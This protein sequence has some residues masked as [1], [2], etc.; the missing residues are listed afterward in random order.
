MFASFDVVIFAGQLIKHCDTLQPGISIER[1]YAPVWLFVKEATTITKLPLPIVLRK[2]ESEVLAEQVV[3]PPLEP[4]TPT[5]APFKSSFAATRL[6]QGFS[7]L[8]APGVPPAP[9]NPPT[10]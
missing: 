1:L 6:L 10:L 9:L 2:P 4:P 3:S 5:A 7:G 8:N